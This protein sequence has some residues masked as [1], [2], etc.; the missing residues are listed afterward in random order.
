VEPPAR[1]DSRHVPAR[2]RKVAST[3]AGDLATHAADALGAR[4]DYVRAAQNHCPGFAE[5]IW[6]RG[7]FRVSVVW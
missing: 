6:L 2:M 4:S 5:R 7:L 3:A 1:P